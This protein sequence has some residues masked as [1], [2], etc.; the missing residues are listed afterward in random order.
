LNDTE[1]PD[2]LE[3]ELEEHLAGAEPLVRQRILEWAR[4]L[5]D[6]TRRNRLL[7]Y[8][9]SK[10]TT[11]VFRE[12]LPEAIAER[13]LDGGTWNLYIPPAVGDDGDKQDL[14]E[15]LRRQPRKAKEVVS[16]ERDPAELAKSLAAIGRRAKAEFDDRAIHTLHLVWGLVRWTDPGSIQEWNAPLVLIPVELGR[17]SRADG[18]EDDLERAF[19]ATWDELTTDWPMVRAGLAWS[20]D[21]RQLLGGGRLSQSLA[22]RLISGMGRTMPWTEYSAS[23]SAQDEAVAAVGARF[24][25]SRN[26]DLINALRGPT[27]GA[28]SELN[29]LVAQID[30]LS[31]W[32][33]F[34]DAANAL[35]AAGWESFATAAIERSAERL[36]LVDSARRAWFSAWSEAVVLSDERLRDFALEEHQRTIAAFGEADRKL[37]KLA[38]ERVLRRYEERKPASVTLQGG[39][40]ALIRREA[41]KRRRHIP[42]RT[43]LGSIPTMLPR[44]K[45][46][47]MMSP[48]SVSHFLTPDMMFDVVVFDEASQVPPEDAINCIYRGNQLIVAGDPKQLP[49]TDFFQ[50]A[51]VVETDTDLETQVDDFESVLDLAQASSYP[52]R[53]LRWHYRS[54]HD[55]LIAF[56]NHFIYANSLVTFPPP[57]RDSEELGVSFVHVPE[58]VFDRGRSAR[59][60]V[61]ASRVVDEMVKQLRARP[62]LSVGV[63]A[64]SVAQQECIQDEWERRLKLEPDLEISTEGDRLRALFIKNLE[65]VQGDERDVI[66]FSIGYGRDETGRFLMNF[67]PLNRSG[68]WR[69]LNVAVTRARRRVIVVSSIRADDFRMAAPQPGGGIVPRGPEL[70]R[71]YLDFAERG[72]LPG[73]ELATASRGTFESAFESDVASAVAQLGYE[74][75]PQVGVS[76]YRV[77]LGV[78]SKVRPSRFAL[79]IECDGAS[80][81][82][83][84]TA[85][86]RDRLREE[87]LRGLGWRIHRVWS[88]DWFHRRALALE[89]IRLAIEAAE[90]DEELAKAAR[91]EMPHLASVR[92][93]GAIR[94]VPPSPQVDLGLIPGTPP[95]PRH[96]HARESV[97]LTDTIDAGR[98]P[99]TTPNTTAA[100][101]SYRSTF[102][103]FHD[104]GLVKEHASRIAGL[105]TA[106][107]PV[108]V[109]VLGA[110]LARQF[111]LQRV[112]SRMAAAIDDAVRVAERQGE[113][114]RKGP[115]IW[116]TGLKDM[117]SVRVPV[118]GEPE[119]LRQID[120]IPPEEIDLALLRILETAVNASDTD[121][122]VAAARIFG[123]GRTGDQ[124]GSVLGNRIGQLNKAGKIV[125]AGDGWRLGI[126]LP[127]ISPKAKLEEFTV[128]DWIR[129]PAW[130][131]GR[132]V[133]TSRGLVTLRYGKVD[134]R[135][136]PKA[137]RLERSAG[138]N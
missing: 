31:T 109:E 100:I 73:P 114:R 66:I 6:L 10:R 113:I 37:I 120:E 128:G 17:P 2:A 26:R 12:P 39:E 56:S 55:S 51:T 88:Q 121:L 53:P 33:Q 102:L 122:R 138:P 58:G 126:E 20:M 4:R 42:V 74:V 137:V 93:S 18:F 133:A 69:R 76:T 23:R 61:E 78:V 38:R 25:E 117:S 34:R 59:N 32:V 134:R 60:S 40:Q 87:I 103:E 30:E 70:L 9:P 29:R 28:L 13:L 1:Q 107:G 97:D 99:W 41:N 90:R 95:E 46:C 67:G 115:F 98:L 110:R 48:L 119:T 44:L 84:K 11:L 89:R 62:D 79:G 124:I 80:Y 96:R 116:P 49:P 130:G 54:R 5:I 85:R 27:E 123:F 135:V 43:L 111:G 64:F 8:K 7:N 3:Q 72:V 15:I 24:E 52:L 22:D 75:R 57:H 127:K 35:Q 63:V 50:L 105:V 16:T 136:D 132:V 83:A 71:A 77:D 81:H 104:P 21:L 82:S 94:E 106:E 36:S 125:A 19:H 91:A 47:L 45:P 92:D 101:L 131:V 129:H 108:H 112:G 86:D 14:D 118:A 65:T 68:G